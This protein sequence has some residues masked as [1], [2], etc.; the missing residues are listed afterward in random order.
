MRYLRLLLEA[1]DWV[2][3]FGLVCA[4]AMLVGLWRLDSAVALAVGGALGF[5][6]SVLAI[7]N[8]RRPRKG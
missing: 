4:A 1:I 8:R 2:E 7:R 3:V 5:A 6:V